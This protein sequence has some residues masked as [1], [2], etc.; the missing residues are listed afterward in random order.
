MRANASRIVNPQDHL[1]ADAV[2]VLADYLLT[3]E[4]DKQCEARD[5]VNGIYSTSR[6]NIFSDIH[7]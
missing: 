4:S 6:F 5:L 1:V 2:Q 7:T 3:E